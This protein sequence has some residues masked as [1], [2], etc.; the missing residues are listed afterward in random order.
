[1]FL[2]VFRFSFVAFAFAVAI[3]V[4][5]FGGGRPRFPPFQFRCIV[6]ASCHSLIGLV[7]GGAANDRHILFQFRCI[8]FAVAKV[9]LA[10]SVGG[11]QAS[12]LFRDP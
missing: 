2:D 6:L 5:S 12:A 3:F 10:S 8:G 1:M 11:S 7:G 9:L 4:W